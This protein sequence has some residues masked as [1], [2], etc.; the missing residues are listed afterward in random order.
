MLGW[1]LLAKP[2]RRMHKFNID[3]L[4]LLQRNWVG[5]GMWVGDDKG[6]FALAKTLWLSHLCNVDAGKLGPFHV[7]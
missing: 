3:V 2:G 1:C 4:F 7:L 5:I 6:S